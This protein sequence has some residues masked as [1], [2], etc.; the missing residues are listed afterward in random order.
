[1]QSWQSK[2]F[3][4]VIW[5]TKRRNKFV[6][7]QSMAQ[8]IEKMKKRP[9]YVLSQRFMQKNNISMFTI[10]EMD[11]YVLNQHSLD[12]E[13]IVYFHGGA[14]INE[15]TN[16]HWRYLQK[17]AA[18]TKKKIYVPI[19]PKLPFSNYSVC[20][21]KLNHFFNKLVER[22][23]QFIFMGDSAGGG[24]ALGFTQSL[25]YAEKKLPTQLI[26][27]SPWLDL[28]GQDVRY[29]ELEPLDP[30]VAIKGAQVLAKLWLGD[31]PDVRNPLISPLYSDIEQLP[32]LTI[33]VGTNELIL[34]DCRRFK[35]RLDAANIHCDYYEF[36]KMNHVFPLF[37][38]P[39]A[40]TV[41]SIILPKLA[42]TKERKR[43]RK[44]A[45]SNVLA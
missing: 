41:W 18:K 19:Y 9:P 43:T 27:F 37:P 16:F 2:T 44:N 26:L 35:E 6:T 22:N 36:E 17:L 11:V 12:E 15:I 4:K 29:Y 40:N 28:E 39:E 8:Y 13:C 23:E 5:M 14:Y 21:D 33:I 3:E 32:P 25:V 38:I 20:Y 10:N 45:F 1:M 30:M 31:A 7:E 24:L 34:L 42:P